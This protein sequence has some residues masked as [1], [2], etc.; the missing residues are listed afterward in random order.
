MQHF[1][2]VYTRAFR[3]VE[4]VE[5]TSD[6]W[7]KRELHYYFI[8]CHR[9]YSGQHNQCDIHAVHDG[10]PLNIQRLSCILISCIFH[11]M[12]WNVI[13][14]YIILYCSLVKI[15]YTLNCTCSHICYILL[16]ISDFFLIHMLWFLHR[17]EWK[18]LHLSIITIYFNFYEC[19]HNRTQIKKCVSRLHVSKLQCSVKCTCMFLK[20][21][22]ESFQDA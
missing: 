18:Y 12:V 10:I 16:L 13:K 21:A 6:K 14:K 22:I 11:G 9:K 4:R 2:V 5:N 20:V 19:M 1:Q 7:N 17:N 3:R 15:I 8:P